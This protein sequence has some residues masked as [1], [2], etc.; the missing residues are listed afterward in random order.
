MHA[1]GWKNPPETPLMRAGLREK[2]AVWSRR[3]FGKC[4]MR[5]MSSGKPIWVIQY[6]RPNAE[7]PRFRRWKALGDCIFL[8]QRPA[9]NRAGELAANPLFD[10]EYRAW[11]YVPKEQK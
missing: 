5:H 9:N 7:T 8:T 11:P 2:L 10:E 4:R 1:N 3:L 6:R